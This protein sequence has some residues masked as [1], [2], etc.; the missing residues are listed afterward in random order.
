MSILVNADSKIIV[1][2]CLQYLQSGFMLVR[3]AHGDCHV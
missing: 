3:P 1:L 2:D